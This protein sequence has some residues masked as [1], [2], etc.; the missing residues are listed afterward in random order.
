MTHFEKNHLLATLMDIAAKQPSRGLNEKVNHV[1]IY[2]FLNDNNG[3]CCKYAA[4]Y[5]VSKF[6]VE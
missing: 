4:R 2:M 6:H 5:H 3:G 1:Y